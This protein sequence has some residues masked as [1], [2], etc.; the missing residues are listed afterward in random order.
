MNNYR[1]TS[2]VISM[3]SQLG[4]EDLR[5]RRARIKTI[6]LFMIVNNLVDIPPGPFLI[7]TGAITRGHNIRFLQPHTRT[8]TMQ[9]SFFPSA[10]RTWNTL[11]QQLGPA[12]LPWRVSDRP[13]PT[14]P[15][16]HRTTPSVF[17][18]YILD[19]LIV[20]GGSFIVSYEQCD[21][22]QPWV[23]HLQ[24]KKVWWSPS[25]LGWPFWISVWHDHGYVPLVI[26]PPAPFL[27]H[28]L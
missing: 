25:W 17:K 1:Q 7:P 6:L 21:Y 3:M 10:I 9:Y 22:T 4:W 28:D 20:H 26:S 2:S 16:Y 27:I 8:I 15:L 23:L 19:I 11:P 18:L 13:W 5:L 24:K 12:W 14:P